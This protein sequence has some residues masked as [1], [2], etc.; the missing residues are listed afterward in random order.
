MPN[1]NSSIKWKSRKRISAVEQGARGFTSTRWEGPSLE[2]FVGFLLLLVGFTLIG[3][4]FDGD[5]GSTVAI[6]GSLIVYAV[7]GEIVWRK[8]PRLANR[9]SWP[10]YWSVFWREF[11]VGLGVFLLVILIELLFRNSGINDARYDYVFGMALVAFGTV[12][13]IIGRKKPPFGLKPRPD[14][15]Q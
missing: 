3:G 8:H 10:A 9:K 5:V 12:L 15:S 11:L 2:G 14:T 4:H 6:L 13:E 7:V 1:S